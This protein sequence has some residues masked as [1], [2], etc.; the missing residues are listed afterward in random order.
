ME[1]AT[2]P[3][4]PSTEAFCFLSRIDDKKHYLQKHV[5]F[6][7]GLRGPTNGARPLVL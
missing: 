1:V 6:K 7:K 5:I 4:V 3:T 2:L